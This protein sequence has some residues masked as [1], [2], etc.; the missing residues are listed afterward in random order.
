MTVPAPV[1]P[2]GGRHLV[3][4]AEI[5]TWAGVREAARD[6]EHFSSDLLGDPDVR[7]IRQ[8]PLE[9]DPP[10]H[11]AY[12]SI[13]APIFGREALL[14]LEPRLA[15][16]ARGLVDTFA[17]R[18]TIEAVTGLA[19][20]MV[21]SS[22]A[23]AFGR[24]GDAEELTSW[25]HTSWE[26]GPDGRRDGSRLDAYV[27]RVLDEAAN[28]PGA[29]AF[30]RIVHAEVDGRPLTR[31]EMVGT[32]N[33]ILAGGRDTVIQLLSAAMWALAER[34]EA[35]ARLR[36]RPSELPVAIDE[37]VRYLSP[38][39]RMERRATGSL[40]GPWGT[41]EADEIVIL[42]YARANHDETVFPDAG[43]LDL[44]RRPNPHVGFGH[45]PHTCIGLNL[46]RL[47][48]RVFL[49][50]LLEAVP[51]WHLGEGVEIRWEAI[52]GHPVPVHLAALP[53]VAEA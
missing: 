49:E 23:L 46:A 43:T 28:R 29:D 27:R 45:G 3:G 30:S 1:P 48:A 39:A 19:I 16:L 47:E 36:A 42:G 50:A 4:V 44:A 5:G 15:G 14:A 41:A 32:A 24:D 33:L 31:D 26:I 12:R 6:W 35:R 21:G 51:D 22:I 9:V 34:P 40:A 7:S 25:G 2:R 11:G 37:L 53:L 38:L 20:P 13:I 8:L 52:E 18:G 10:A 17:R